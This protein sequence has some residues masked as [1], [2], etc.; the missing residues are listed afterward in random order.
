[1]RNGK[2]P[3]SF[4][5]LFL[6]GKFIFSFTLMAAYFVLKHNNVYVNEIY[7]NLCNQPFLGEISYKCI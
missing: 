5:G 2:K 1:M 7:K 4:M 6:T 3:R